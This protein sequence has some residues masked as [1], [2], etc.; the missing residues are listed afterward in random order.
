MNRRQSSLPLISILMMLIV[1]CVIMI[2]IAV[3]FLYKDNTNNDSTASSTQQ[4]AETISEHAGDTS[5]TSDE[6]P[7]TSAN[8]SPMAISHVADADTTG[9]KHVPLGTLAVLQ[10]DP[11]SHY[12]FVI[13][14]GSM[15]LT[16]TSAAVYASLEEANASE[17]IGSVYQSETGIEEPAL[18]VIHMRLQNIDAINMF[19][20]TNIYSISEFTPKY[21][22]PGSTS[23][24][25]SSLATFNGMM[26][27][28]DPAN[29]RGGNRFELLPGETRDF[30][31]SA[32]FPRSSISSLC[33]MPS[34]NDSYHP[35]IFDL[36][37]SDY[38]VP[39]A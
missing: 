15:E 22:S 2:T 38:D 10:N 32:W 11:N 19:D 17:D 28:V 14:N 3:V 36:G 5:A 7:L 6:A 35:Y 20:S 4:G 39:T 30:V 31:F 26:E 37:L 29:P 34:L 16:V 33:I 8:T 9:D 25:V 21:Q 23:W 12:S 27:G 1:I 18:V 13:W 24:T